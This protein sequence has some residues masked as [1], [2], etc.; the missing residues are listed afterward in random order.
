MWKT[1]WAASSQGPYPVGNPSAQPDQ[2]FAFPDPL[3]GANDQTMRLVVRPTLWGEQARLRFSNTFGTKP[4]TLD[5]VFVGLQMGGAAIVPTTNRSVTF[6]GGQAVT[7]A[8]GGSVWSDAVALPF[9][10]D[11]LFFG[12]KLVVSFHIVGESGPM[13]WHAKA[14]QT[15]YATAPG[16]GARGH[17]EGEAA[18]PTARRR[19]SSLPR[20]T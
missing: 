1:S 13:T 8:P 18:S 12:R 11:G 10:D 4:L 2:R 15:S 6:S 17:E 9:A 19:G 5:G 3:V 7:I 14:L 16:A 20:S